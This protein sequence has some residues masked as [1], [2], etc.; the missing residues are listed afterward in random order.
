[1]MNLPGLRALGFDGLEAVAVERFRSGR[2]LDRVQKKGHQ[3]GT[4]HLIVGLHK[5]SVGTTV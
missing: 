2:R 5:L 1:M 4:W 3:S